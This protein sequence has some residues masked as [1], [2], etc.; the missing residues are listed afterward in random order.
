MRVGKY[1]EIFHPG[2]DESNGLLKANWEMS[3]ST[4]LEIICGRYPKSSTGRE[5]KVMSLVLS[6]SVRHSDFALLWK[7][8]NHYDF[9]LTVR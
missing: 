4:P 5:G 1:L 9:A 3:L 7:F 6:G 2:V 8:T